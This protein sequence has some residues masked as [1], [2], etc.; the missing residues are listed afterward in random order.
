MTD[1]QTRDVSSRYPAPDVRRGGR[2][3]TIAAFV[4]AAIAVLILPPVFGIAGIVLG[5]VGRSKGDRELGKWAI[6]ASIAGM[7]LGFVLGAIV[8]SASDSNA[9]VGWLFG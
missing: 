6:I 2:G 4:C 9:A 8:L 7:I 3:F 1:L 5:A